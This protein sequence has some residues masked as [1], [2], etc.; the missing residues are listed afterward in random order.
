MTTLKKMYVVLDFIKMNTEAQK[1]FFK[2]LL[3]VKDNT[4][5]HMELNLTIKST[6]L[7]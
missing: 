2:V 3:L 5:T 4:K 7:P 1:Y 6:F